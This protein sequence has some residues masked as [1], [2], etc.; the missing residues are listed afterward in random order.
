METNLYGNEGLN[1]GA[2]NPS[3][4]LLVSFIKGITGLKA[5]IAHGSKSQG[6]LQNYLG[7]NSLPLG[8]QQYCTRHFRQESYPNLDEVV[9]QILKHIR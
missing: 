9:E 5:V 2:G 1:G 7:G 4:E 3:S 6:F 8:V